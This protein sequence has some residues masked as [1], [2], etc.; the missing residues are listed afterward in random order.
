MLN[1]ALPIRRTGG[2][3]H[4]QIGP[5]PG[6]LSSD[7]QS[8]SGLPGGAGLSADLADIRPGPPLALEQSCIPSLASG[9]GIA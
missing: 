7:S 5:A 1:L 3:R 2:L 4:Y 8:A 6:M 9:V